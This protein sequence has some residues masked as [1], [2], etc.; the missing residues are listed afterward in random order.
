M[1]TVIV[2]LVDKGKLYM[3]GDRSTSDEKYIESMYEPKVSK[4][5]KILFGYAGNVGV[6][7]LIT[8]QFEFPQVETPEQFHSDFTPALRAFIKEQGMSFSPDD[9]VE[10]LVGAAGYM[11]AMHLWDF[12]AIPYSKTALGSGGG[13]ALGSLYSDKSKSMNTRIENAIEAAC[14]YVTTCKLPFDI[15]SA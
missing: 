9:D 10:C 2:G 3:G 4:H 12:Q 14:E 13:I 5:G 15:V 7:Q 8:Y 6:G 11:W 1:L